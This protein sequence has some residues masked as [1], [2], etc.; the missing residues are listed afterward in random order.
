MDEAQPALSK[1]H[2]EITVGEPYVDSAIRDITLK[3]PSDI[4]PK[5]LLVALNGK[6]ITF[7]FYRASCDSNICETAQLTTSDGIVSGKN[8]L[9]ALVRKTDGTIV[10]SR[11]RFSGVEASASVRQASGKAYVASRATASSLTA[12]TFLPPAVALTINPVTNL[13]DVWITA[14]NTSYGGMIN[15]V[16]SLSCRASNLYSAVV[17]DR[18]TLAEKTSAPESSGQCF[19][20]AKAFSTYLKTLPAGDLVIAGT[21]L[22]SNTDAGSANGVLDAT[23]IGGSIFNCYCDQAGATREVPL[24]YLVVGVSGA[25]PGTAYEN[26]AT[27]PQYES[28]QSFAIGMLEEDASGNYNFRSSQPVEYVINP[29][30]PSNNNQATITLSGTSTFSRYQSYNYPDK[31]VFAAP[32]GTNGFW[33]L[34]LRRDNF[35]YV[36]GQSWDYESCNANGDDSRQL[37]NMTGCGHFYPTGSTDAATASQAY[38]DLQNALANQLSFNDLVFLVSVGNAINPTYTDAFGLAN[39][40]GVASAAYKFSQGL[41]LLGGTPGQVQ[42]LFTPGSTYSFVTCYQCGNSLDGHAVLSTTVNAQQGQTGVVHGLFV[43]NGNGLYWPGRASQESV[44]QVTNGGGSDFTM[45]RVTAQQPV[46]WPELSGTLLSGASSVEGQVAAYHYLSYQ[47]VTQHYI[48]GA[49]GNYLDDIHFY[50]TGSNNTYLDYHTFDPVSVPYPDPSSSCYAWLDPVTNT[51]LTCFTP[52]DLSAVAAQVSQEVVDLDNVLQFMVNGSTN[53][54]DIVAAGNGSVATALIGAASAVEGSNLQP[55]PAS[56]VTANAS[57]ILNLFSAVTNL[58][59]QAA[60]D[61]LITD[62]NLMNSLWSVGST[63]ADFFDLSSSVAGGY[64]NSGTSSPPS[65]NYKV[66]IA[67]SQLANGQLQQQ[68]I[69]GFDTELDNILS[70]WGKLSVLGPLITNSNNLTFY[71]PNQIAQNAAV[72]E[73]GKAAQRSFYMSLLPVSYSV[74]FYP[75]WWRDS[76]TTPANPP[77]MGTATGNG[78]CNSWYPWGSRDASSGTILWP[79]RAIYHASYAG[80]EPVFTYDPPDSMPIDYFVLASQTV[81][82]K[83]KSNQSIAMLDET[84][85]NTMFSAGGL[86]IPFDPFVMPHGPMASVFWDVTVNNFTGYGLNKIYSCGTNNGGVGAVRE[87]PYLTTTV[88]TVPATVV[89]KDAVE[90]T[91]KVTAQAGIPAGTVSFESK[92]GVLGEATLDST[93]TAHLTVQSLPVGKNSITAY[94]I[95][96]GNYSSSQSAAATV[97]VYPGEPTMSL[98]MSVDHVDVTYGQDSTTLALQIISRFGLAG[99]LTFSCTGLPVGMTCSFNPSTVPITLDGTA[100]TSFTI[101]ANPIQTAGLATTRNVTIVLAILCSFICLDRARRTRRSIQYL[102]AILLLTTTLGWIMGCSGGGRLKETGSRT[103]LVNATNGNVNKTI[104]LVVNI[105]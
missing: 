2:V 7:R 92:D 85:T 10:S 87:D 19:S 81:N 64:T 22:T 9:Y 17:L 4:D 38:T 100:S 83:G 47:L 46:A 89:Y 13:T 98:S 80:Q 57:S 49:Q 5:T 72:V 33:L 94:Y 73:L 41:E 52:N 21:S 29:S 93:G 96:N 60:S 76:N 105:Q 70:D 37:T 1:S 58:G 24:S 55:A 40:S 63:I 18:K 31:L 104:P 82:N 90:L 16:S 45:A 36:T 20:D 77:N 25:T 23:S 95:V 103:I 48:R 75:R 34:Y 88:L 65:P 28:F 102:A 53:L 43:R 35:D 8:V 30:D 39:D 51:T 32:S 27:A 91:A 59:L 62:E 12:N 99:N 44:N 74:Q 6:D 67:I 66:K 69:A 14:G 11:E 50:F 15:G 68:L 42:Q 61:G 54:K 79:T 26:Y 97:D 71:A 56:P 3:L 101:K 84:V 78:N 86:N